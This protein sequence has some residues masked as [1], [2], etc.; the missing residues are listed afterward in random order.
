[1][2]RERDR[3]WREGERDRERDYGERKGER[4]RERAISNPDIVKSLSGMERETEYGERGRERQREREAER[5]RERERSRNPILSRR[6]LS[7]P[8]EPSR[9]S[10]P[11]DPPSLFFFIT[12]KPRVE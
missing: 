8:P 2:D 12:L 6:S 3:V 9:F 11:R 1:M 5:G 10:T 7:G 4:G